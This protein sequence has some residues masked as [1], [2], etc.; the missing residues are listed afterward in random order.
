MSTIRIQT[1]INSDT[2]V[3]PQLKEL[4]GKTV[5]I[6]ITERADDKI[7]DDKWAAAERAFQE[8]RDYDFDALPEQRAYDLLHAED[9]LK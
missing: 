7:S 4:L 9:H 2:L 6:Q 8:I 3:L 5:D 1:T